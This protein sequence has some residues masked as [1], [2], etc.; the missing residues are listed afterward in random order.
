[1]QDTLLNRMTK[2]Y[3]RTQWIIIS[4]VLF[5]TVF[6]LTVGIL[7]IALYKD[8]K[9]ILFGILVI[10]FAV[11]MFTGGLIAVLMT[12][13]ISQYAKRQ[14]LFLANVSHELRS[15]LTAIKMYAQTLSEGRCKDNQNICINYILTSTERLDHLIQQILQWKRISSNKEVLDIELINAN[16]PMIDAIDSFK[17]INPDFNGKLIIELG[18]KNPI[19]E[20]DRN[21]LSRAL[22]NILD[23]AD[24]YAKENKEIKIKT[25]VIKESN[26]QK[27]FQYE[28]SDNGIG[29]PHDKLSDIFDE[30]YRVNDKFKG[31]AGL[32][33]GLGIA[34]AIT[35]AHG[36]SL[37]VDSIEEKGSTF[38]I[39]IPLSIPTKS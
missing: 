12:K 39:R 2:F 9:D 5:P 16:T 14:S 34:K 20:L 4:L 1:M 38:Y 35:N 8:I 18:E 21:A 13:R 7:G 37:F 19:I 26:V 10:C 32:G 25:S 33:L 36:G 28:I 3:R 27:F 17:S 30:F 29:I 15:P 23:N 22:Y 31:Q 6:T 24:K 11:S